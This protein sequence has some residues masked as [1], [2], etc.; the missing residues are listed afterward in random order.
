MNCIN[1]AILGMFILLGIACSP[2][3]TLPDLINQ[4]PIP[5]INTRPVVQAGEDILDYPFTTLSLNATMSDAE[6]NIRTRNWTKI[7]GPGDCWIMSKNVENTLVRNLSNGKYLFEITV[8][9]DGG[10]IAKDTIMASINI[11]TIENG[12]F[13]FNNLSWSFPW[14]AVVAIP[15]FGM[16]VPSD[17]K[18]KVYIQ[19]D[20]STTWTEV[21][22]S[23]VETGDYE[24]H[25]ET[26]IA[27][28]IYNYNSLYVHYWNSDDAKD[29]PNVKIVF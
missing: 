15:D 23:P 2:E 12:E 1:T 16:N 9:D 18:Y 28:G 20:G 17:K 26:R 3:K 19:R 13:I 10:L 21:L 24:Y 6:D 25:L 8:M 27:S 7:S 29:S 22:P 4:P 14:Y 5:R 11:Q